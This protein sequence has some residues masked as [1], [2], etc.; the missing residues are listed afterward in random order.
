M[1]QWDN[2]AVIDRHHTSVGQIECVVFDLG[3]VLLRSPATLQPLARRLGAPDS[4]TAEI[5]R[6]A[7][8]AP[9]PD[10]DRTSDAAAYWTAVA[11]LAGAPPPEPGDIADLTAIDLAAWSRVETGTLAVADALGRAGVGLAVLSNAPISMGE[12]IRAQP[13]ARVFDHVL[14]SGE[15]GLVKPDPGIYLTLLRELG[16]PAGRVAFTDDLA[17]NI[18][19]ADAVGIRAIPFTGPDALRRD[20]AGLG[21]P[22]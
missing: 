8:Q 7:Y 4:V 21:L 9:R 15:I 2:D 6:S 14:I 13:W 1:P 18:A 22:L 19:G 5:F 20:L 12:H 16:L 11:K 17:A 10:Y 3:N